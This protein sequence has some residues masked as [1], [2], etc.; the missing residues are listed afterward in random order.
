MSIEVFGNDHKPSLMAQLIKA[1]IRW[2]LRP[3]LA[4]W[5]PLGLQRGL[6][7]SL[8]WLVPGP[9]GVFTQQINQHGF[10]GDCHQ[11]QSDALKNITILY[12]HGGGYSV[13]SPKSHRGLTKRLAI[14]ARCKVFVPKYRLAPEH[15]FPAQLSDAQAAFTALEALGISADNIIV[16][17]DSAG[18]HL[19][20]TLALSRRD[21]GLPLPRALVLISPWVDV[22]LQN[23]PS[24]ADDALLSIPWMTQVRDAFVKK[25]QWLDPMV[26]P[27]QANLKGLPPVLIQFS[28]LEQLSNDAKRLHSALQEANVKVTSQQWTGL[29]HD[30]QLHAGMVLEATNALEKIASFIQGLKKTT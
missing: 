3:F 1:Q 16:I 8:Q 17:G 20:L 26:S 6:A 14:A 4:P 19:S 24:D 30:F 12:L 10:S 15:P 29:W 13:C 27:I 23:M 2:L 18:A 11:P 25:D 7:G 21:A 22:S 5:S 9:G 28:S